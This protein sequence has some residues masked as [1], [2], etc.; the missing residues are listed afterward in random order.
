VPSSA[1]P[2]DINLDCTERYTSCFFVLLRGVSSPLFAPSKELGLSARG[3]NLLSHVV[4]RQALYDSN[5]VLPDV[6][7]EALMAATRGVC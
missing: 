5:K 3:L 7:A 2:N 6:N 1:G 4:Q